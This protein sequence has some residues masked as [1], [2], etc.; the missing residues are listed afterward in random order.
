[1]YIVYSDRCLEYVAPYLPENPER[2]YR[3]YRLLKTK[4]M[5]FIPPEACSEEDLRLVHSE[6]LIERIRSGDFF[7]PDSPSLPSIYEYARLSVGGAIK[8]MEIA[9]SGEKAFSL[10]RPPGHHV[11]VSGAAL[12]AVSMGFCY[13]NNVAVACMKALERVGRVAILDIDCHHGNGTQE[14]FQGNPRVIFVSLHKYGGFYPGTGGSSEDNCLNYPFR[15]PVGDEEY[16][17]TLRKAIRKIE[18]F[19]PDLLAVSAGFDAHR[20]DPVGALMLSE[21]AFV[22]IGRLIAEMKRDTF[23][24]LEGGYGRL[25]PECVWNF[26]KGLGN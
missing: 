1:M 6:E 18:K 22:E 20:D 12:G 10:M 16:L 13:F 25:F 8:S 14:I 9:L 4:G 19:N 26:I 21:E 24:V 5:R 17:E 2:I 23:A 7:D 15:Q 11:G 3:A